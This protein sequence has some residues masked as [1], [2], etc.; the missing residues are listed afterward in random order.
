MNISID[1]FKNLK[2][3][4]KQIFNLIQKKGY[5]TKGEISK[6]TN[7][8]ITTLNYIMEP[9]E[10]N[11]LIIERCVGES[12][13]GRKP[14]LYDINLCQFYII[15]IDISPAYT[16]VV[17]TNLKME[18]LHTENFPMD[19]SC[20][21]NSTISKIVEIIN[22][23][24]SDLNLDYI[25]LFGV[26]LAVT[27]N[28][29]KE[30][31]VITT[32]L[33]D[34][35][36]AW[37]NVPVK[38]ILEDY[39][40]SPVFFENGSNC[41]VIAEYYYGVG[42]GFNNLAYFNCGKEIRTGTIFS[43]RLLRTINDVED[44]FSHITIDNNGKKCTCG[45]YG[46]LQS[47]TSI[48]SIAENFLSE[49]KSGKTTIIDKPIEDIEFKDICLAAEK[50]DSLSKEVI[51]ES[52]IIFGT[53]LANYI[54]IV[55]PDSVILNGS[56]IMNSKLFYEKSIDIVFK[57]LHSERFKNILFSRGGYFKE[58]TIAIGA[59]ALVVEKYLNNWL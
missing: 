3:D 45:N 10:Q 32:A 34:Y 52:A 54:S 49:I 33:F 12:T 59:A 28:I 40:D 41:G 50:N 48:G 16:K 51:K 30:K 36:P 14:I 29:D 31:G 22:K 27:G 39:L 13:G 46:C 55:N 1:I 25:K 43:G 11:S 7:L 57:K 17:F 5:M 53:A 56:T 26:G 58:N 18:I 42:K 19:I 23:V 47:Y 4:A 6:E 38:K 21:P 9:M 24:K 44:S 37:N 20:T 35:S 8:K 15:G 2:H